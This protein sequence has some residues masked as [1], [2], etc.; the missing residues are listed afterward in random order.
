MGEST[1]G[2][3]TPS[4]IRGVRG[5]SPE[6]IFKIKMSVEAILMHFETIF[7]CETRLIVH[8]VHEAVYLLPLRL[9]PISYTTIP[10][11]IINFHKVIKINF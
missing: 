6:K 10:C 7:A 11:T 8:T 3:F 1:R 5:V 9:L 2:V 4:C